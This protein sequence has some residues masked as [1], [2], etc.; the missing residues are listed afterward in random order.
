MTFLDINAVPSRHPVTSTFCV[1]GPFVLWSTQPI[2]CF[3]Y[4]F[5]KT[6]WGGRRKKCERRPSRLP[7]ICILN[8][9]FRCTPKR[10][11]PIRA[12]AAC[13]S[14]I[15]HLKQAGCSRAQRRESRLY[16]VG[17]WHAAAVAYEKPE[18]LGSKLGVDLWL[19]YHPRPS[20]SSL[21]LGTKP[22]QPSSSESDTRKVEFPSLAILRWVNNFC[23]M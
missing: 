19:Q 14:V 7:G 18:L 15:C 21:A 8:P 2:E 4:L 11:Y 16:T 12:N 1:Q 22:A 23:C 5:C 20:R 9:M 17:R 10:L 6:F 13:A 3:D